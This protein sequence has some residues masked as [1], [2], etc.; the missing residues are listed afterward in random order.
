MEEFQVSRVA[1]REALRSLENAGLLITR[2]GANGGTYIIELSFEQ[3]ANAFLDLFLAD[4]ISMPELCHVRLLI[5]PEIARLATINITP[6]QKIRLQEIIREE[7][8][9]M[10]SLADDIENK[11]L[12][13]SLLAE[14]CGN[15]FL[16]ALVKS[17]MGVT[18]KVVLAVLPTPPFIH[19][20]GMHNEIV[21]AVLEGK[22][23][24]AADAMRRH[25]LEFNAI[26]IEMERGFRKK[27]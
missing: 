23:D 3:M 17:L 20:P 11:T 5:E 10:K 26:L 13:H 2:P 18:R 24:E 1:V 21:K 22:P 19:P 6:E 25:A 15:R 4:K 7:E 12:V 14:A 27:T 8:M 16:E 9:P